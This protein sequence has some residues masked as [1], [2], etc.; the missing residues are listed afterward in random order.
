MGCCVLADD[1]DRLRDILP[2]LSEYL[3]QNGVPLIFGLALGV[4][5]NELDDNL[6]VLVAGG[7]FGLGRAALDLL[8]VYLCRL[9]DLDA[10]DKAREDD[11]VELDAFVFNEDHGRPPFPYAG[12]GA[13]SG[14]SS[15]LPLL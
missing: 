13:A 1:R 7:L 4:I 14:S 11:P 6:G 15:P 3:A 9:R 10:F 12:L 2:R 8:L 5:D